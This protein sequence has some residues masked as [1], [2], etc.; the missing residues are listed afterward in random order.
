MK[1]TK[2][3]G[4]ALL[5]VLISSSMIAALE[6]QTERHNRDTVAG[7]KVRE[8]ESSRFRS[9]RSGSSRGSGLSSRSN[10]S[11]SLSGRSSSSLSGRLSGS[12]S[13]RSSSIARSSA[14]PFGIRGGLY[15]ARGWGPYYSSFWGWGGAYWWPY[16][17][18]R[19]LRGISYYPIS[20][21][22]EH[23]ENCLDLCES[24]AAQC[25]NYRVKYDRF[26]FLK[27][28]CGD[29]DDFTVVDKYCWTPKKCVLAKEVGCEPI[30][31][32]ILKKKKK[33]DIEDDDE[34]VD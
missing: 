33:F 23:R 3:L 6:L 15:G 9:G 8:N 1:L 2:F 27:C 20:Y 13:G 28:S 19:W 7:K 21:I 17:S 32:K 5:T 18:W 25:D 10:S 30:I 31:R 12:L 34:I 22:R 26:G 29:S 11:S 24:L 16:F 4:C 14:R